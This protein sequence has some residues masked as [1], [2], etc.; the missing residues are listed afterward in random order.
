M[1]GQTLAAKAIA[2]SDKDSDLEPFDRR[3]ARDGFALGFDAEARAALAGG[4]N[5]V[6]GDCLLHSDKLGSA[7]TKRIPPFASCT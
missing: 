5:A 7:R 4:G 3:K 6:I 1:A 2:P